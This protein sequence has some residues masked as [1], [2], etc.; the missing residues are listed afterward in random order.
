MQNSADFRVKNLKIQAKKR[1]AIT[2]DSDSF[3]EDNHA[4]LS[5]QKSGME[6]ISQAA[7]SHPEQ[8]RD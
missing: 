6:R 5:P 7:R 2:E 4:M 3:T 1:A 8:R